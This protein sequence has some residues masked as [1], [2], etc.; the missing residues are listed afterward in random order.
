VSSF[1]RKVFGVGGRF[2]LVKGRVGEESADL[3][4]VVFSGVGR[5]GLRGGRGMDGVEGMLVW[6]FRGEGGGAGRAAAGKKGLLE[7]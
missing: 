4:M 1:G 3:V 2:L 7:A 5:R 6:I